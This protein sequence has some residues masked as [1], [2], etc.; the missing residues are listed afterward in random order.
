MLPVLQLYPQGYD[1][2]KECSEAKLY[3][4][5]LELPVFQKSAGKICEV[6]L[7]ASLKKVYLVFHYYRHFQKM[8]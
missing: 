6:S 8:K 3:W 4:M 5:I 1:A 2:Q 7:K